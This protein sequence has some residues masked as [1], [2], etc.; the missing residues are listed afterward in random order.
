[1]CRRGS[2]YQHN[3]WWVWRS[4]LARQIVALEA[5]GSS[6]TIHLNEKS[7]NLNGLRDFLMPQ[8]GVS[9]CIQLFLS[10]NLADLMHLCIELDE[11]IYY[12]APVPS[13]DSVDMGEYLTFISKESNRKKYSQLS[14]TEKQMV[15][16][17]GQLSKADQQD[18]MDFLKI[19]YHRKRSLKSRQ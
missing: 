15:F 14:D 4:W 9:K 12:D 13:Q 16:Y 10:Q 6:P 11:D 8:T 2:P 5:V 19:K 1:M 18:I 7:R 17:Y 3:I